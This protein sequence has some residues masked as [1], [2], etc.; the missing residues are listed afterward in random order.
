LNPGLQPAIRKFI[1]LFAGCVLFHV[2]G[3]WSIPLIDRDE[4]RFAEASREMRERHD[5]VV[6]FLNNRYRFDKPPLTYWCQVVSFRVFGENEF[7]ARFPSAVAAALTSLLLFAWGRSVGNERL[8]W[9][10]AIIFATSLQV[11]I[12]AKAAV[13]DMWLVCFMTAAHWAGFELLGLRSNART[14]S[15]SLNE[16]KRWWWLFYIS[17]AFAF[18]TKGP[19]GWIPIL[20][21][22]ILKPFLHRPDLDRRFHFLLGWLVLLG[23]VAL[24]GI[25]ALVRTDGEFFWTGVGKHV[26]NRAVISMEGHGGRSMA[27]G[28]PELFPVVDKAAVALPTPLAHTRCDR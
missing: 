2:A 25:P 27:R 24:W 23:I 21:V 3:T 6:P 8:G 16:T 26:V 17:L 14:S 28:F 9:W 11:F 4:P 7:G 12:H 1:L 18:L 5:Y 13:A 22:V 10:A 20:T 19:T 15:E